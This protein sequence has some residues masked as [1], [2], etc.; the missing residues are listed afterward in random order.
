[1]ASSIMNVLSSIMHRPITLKFVGI[2]LDQTFGIY[3]NYFKKEE[4]RGGGEFLCSSMT[5]NL[6]VM[7]VALGSIY[8]TYFYL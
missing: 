1:M 8:R 5:F 7:N 6:S 2:T 4:R 3:D